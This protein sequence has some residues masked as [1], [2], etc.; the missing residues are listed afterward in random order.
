MQPTDDSQPPPPGPALAAEALYRELLERQG[1]GFGMVDDQERFLVV[2][3]VAEKILGVPPGQLVGRSL[4]DFLDADQ[5]VLVRGESGLRAQG[6]SSTYELRIRREDGTARTVLVT[7]TPRQDPQGVGT[8]V[9][10]VFRDITEQKATEQRLRASEARFRAYV[11]QSTDVIFTLDARGTF[12][13]VSPAWERH[14]GFPVQEVMGQPFT[15]FVHP[16]DIQPCLDYLQRILATGRPE[17]SPPYRVRRADGSWRWLVAN[18]S[19]MA[20]AG[21]ETHFIGVARDI[22]DNKAIGEALRESEE[23]FRVLFEGA[24]DAIVLAD[25]E[26]GT[27]LDANQAACEM[28]GRERA[29][30]PGMNQL[31][32]HPSRSG[33][34]S[35]ETFHRHVAESRAEGLTH[36][37]EDLVLRSDGVEIPVEVVARMVRLHDQVVLMGTFRD[38][39]ERKRTEEGLARSQAELK[40]IYDHS[41][42]MMCVADASNRVLYVNPAFAAFT[43]T[44]QE[45]LQGESPGGVLGCL[46]A[47]GNPNGC[48]AG[49]SCSACTL[50]QALADTQ[51]TGATHHNIEFHAQI[52]RHGLPS[53]VSFLASTSAF[54]AAGSRQL[55]LC[56]ND[57]SERKAAEE[58]LKTSEA[59]YRDQ[60]N[61]ASEGIYTLSPEGELLEVNESSARMHGYTVPQMRGLKL[62]DLCW[63]ET[64]DLTRKRI[65]RILA[66]EALTYQVDHCH[67]DGHRLPL[68]V[69]ASLISEAGQPRILMFHRD[70]T[71]RQKVE[72]ALRASEA[73]L[74]T[75]FEAS[76]AGIILVS[77]NGLIAFANRRMAELFG[78]SLAALIGSPYLGHLHPSEAEQS[79]VRMRMLMAGGL[80]SVSVERRYLRADGSDF[81]GHLSGRRLE[82]PDGSLR[83]L[84]GIVTDITARRQAEEE[85]RHLQAQLHQAQKMESLGSLAGGMAHDMNNVLGAILGL[86]SAHMDSLPPGS[87]AQRAFGTIIKAA[88]RGGNMLKSLLS[89]ARQNT[90]ELRELDL[91]GILWEEVR[92]LERTTLSKV[93]LVMDLSPDLHA[94]Q[95]DAGALTHALM[96]LC[97]N[98]VDAMADG[99]TLTFRTRNLEPGWVEVQVEDTGAGMPREVL[100]KALDPFFTTK[101]VGKGTGLGLSIV[102]STVKAHQGQMELR[103]EPGRGT[104]VLMRFPAHLR[105]G[106]P[107]EPAGAGPPK[108]PRRSLS[109]LLVDDDDLIQ[110]AVQGLLSNLGHAVSS[111]PCGEEALA[112]IEAGLHPDLVILDVNMPGLGGAGTL[113]RLRTLLPDVPVLLATG[114]ADQTALDLVEHHPFVTLLT[115]PFGLRELEASLGPF[116]RR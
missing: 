20:A 6:Y 94:I 67:R 91:N 4:L 2:N 98:A 79:D 44:R 116:L 22:T 110:S 74:R 103:S 105:V 36:P 85:Q 52:L 25:P 93:R 57:I 38:I 3:P 45:D 80:P 75:I 68:E 21:G 64:M 114:R 37:I 28:L 23:R 47:L 50:R 31:E 78:T 14:F 111:A 49:P 89:F 76:E 17:T 27:L 96:N 106:P 107:A 102:Y 66:G 26:T 43:G 73:Q 5:R 15:P 71:D 19:S 88:E 55:L 1:D 46:Q 42:V 56:L 92:L 69:S 51:A 32:L 100:E 59:R 65:R 12:Q 97:V 40:A 8:Q 86:A 104:C 54:E 90:A 7:A 95:G 9:I 41:P 34:R 53:R 113:P 30:I 29:R 70:I 112:R 115:K 39:S 58:A 81:W 33:P 61:M 62:V 10:G 35:R 11:E 60:F 109:I 87:P 99:G 18:G 24:P 82:N 101:E 16:E 77:P 63:P 84:L 83:A 108:V 13:F 48:G 72:E